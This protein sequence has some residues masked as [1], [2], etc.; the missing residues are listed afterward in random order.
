MSTAS[1]G[2]GG[3]LSSRQVLWSLLAHY[4]S[5]MAIGLAVGGFVPLIAVTLEARQVD[6]VMIGINSAMTS[7]G[8]LVMAPYATVMVR[9]FGA[10][11]AMVG[12]LLVTAVSALAMAFIDNIW[13]WMVLRFLIGAGVSIHWVV[14]ET[15]MNAIISERRRG[16][17]MSIYITSIAS[18]FALGPIILTLIGTEGP[19]PFVVIAAI[20]ALTALPLALI[21]N[22][23]PPLALETKG[24][25]I[26][27]ARDA[28]TIFAAVLTVGLIDAAFFTFLPIYG[29]R[30]GMPSDTAVT[31]LTA[32]FAG[33]MALQIPLGWLAD[34]VNRRGMLLVL[35]TICIAC[36]GLV[37]W[38]LRADSLA[39]YPILFF[40]GGCSFGLYTVGVTMLGERY[41]GGELVAA[42]AA[43]VMTFELANLFGPPLSGWA[44][45]AWVPTGLMV[46]MSCICAGF[47]LLSLIRGWMRVRGAVG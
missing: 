3:A 22:L 42:N 12:G 32:V 19:A 8:V 25:V 10:S 2:S 20:T 41:R 38:L 13:A 33:N 44:M 15:W 45:E 24:S 23:A 40:W 34:R 7:L 28:P 1:S 6:T 27:L 37:A 39:A 17:V 30:I 43:F 4:A 35:G 14:S 18:G 31:L 36:P 21:R 16:L 47:V 26:R 46:Y 5:S 29:I 11:P 9:R